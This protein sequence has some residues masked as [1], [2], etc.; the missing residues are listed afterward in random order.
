MTFTFRV[1]EWYAGEE[2]QPGFQTERRSWKSGDRFVL[3]LPMKVRFED[4]PVSGRSVTRG[5]LV[6]SYS[7]PS[8]WQV[9]TLTYAKLAGKKCGNPDFKSWTITPSAKW[10]YA[11]E[12]CCPEDVEVV[13]DNNGGFPFDEG[14]SPVKLRVKAA[15]VKDWVLEEGRYTPALPDN[16]VIAAGSDTTI[17]LVPYGSTTIRVTVFPTVSR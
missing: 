3:N 10:N 7:I 5:P 14:C 6:Y 8:D 2:L 16:P 1:P 4:N 13:F 11:L 15:E 17:E 9:D 12:S